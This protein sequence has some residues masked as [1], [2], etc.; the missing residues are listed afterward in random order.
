[1]AD[2]NKNLVHESETQRQY[3][4]V[5]LPAKARIDGEEYIVTNISSAGLS[6]ED[7]DKVSPGKQF[8]I[9]LILPFHGFSLDLDLDAEV[10]HYDEKNKILGCRFTNL[11]PEKASVINNVIRGHIAGDVVNSGDIMNVVARENYV[12]V[13]HHDKPQP[14]AGDFWKRQA[15]PLLFIALLG[16]LAFSI[17][18][19]NIYNGLFVLESSQAYVESE[20]TVLRNPSEGVYQPSIEPDIMT[21][22]TGQEIGRIVSSQNYNNESARGLNVGQSVIISPCDCFIL[23]RPVKK[24]EYIPSGSNVIELVET[25]ATPWV[26][27][28]VSTREAQRIAIGDSADI[29]IAGS[30]LEVVGTVSGFQV[31]DIGG[32]L[33]A[34]SEGFDTGVQVRIALDQKI[35][36]DLTGRPARVD[37]NI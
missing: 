12:N 10:R 19:S 22:Q 23:A 4:R 24:G 6:I 3:V 1:M 25:T 32:P 16:M 2:Q 7:I 18:A 17:I 35:P 21:V 29:Y 27:A 37:F 9:V 15:L 33:V 31:N 8:P 36:V 11:T 30:D 14:S 34:R 28:V 20:K 13:R 5:E 26:I